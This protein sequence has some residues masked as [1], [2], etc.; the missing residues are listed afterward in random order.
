MMMTD[1]ARGAYEAGATDWTDQWSHGWEKVGDNPE[2]TRA[3]LDRSWENYL[4]GEYDK[5][6]AEA[7]AEGKF[8][9]D[10]DDD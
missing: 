2:M 9:Y 4:S 3:A 6:V 7:V 1:I 5:E 10:E 8:D